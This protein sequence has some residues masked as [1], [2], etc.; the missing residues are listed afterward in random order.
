MPEITKRRVT[1]RNTIVVGHAPDTGA[2]ILQDQTA[3]DFVRPDFLDSYVSDARTRWQSVTVSDAPDAGP[4]GY[5]G[6]T[7]VPTHLG[8]EGA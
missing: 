2:P 6:D 1:M 4:A 7:I 5:S 3:E 8:T